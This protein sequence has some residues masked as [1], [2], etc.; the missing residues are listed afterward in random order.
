MDANVDLK[1]S[2]DCEIDERLF[3]GVVALVGNRFGERISCTRGMARYEP[4]AMVMRQDSLFDMASVTKVLAVGTAS[5]LLLD[6]NLLDL[7]SPIGNY[8]PELSSEA[9]RSIP[10]LFLFTHTS[11]LN[12]R[13]IERSGKAFFEELM[14]IVPDEAPGKEFCYSCLNFILLGLV[15]EKVS[16]ESLDVFCEKRIFA[17]FG[18]QNTGFA[19]VPESDHL[20]DVSTSKLGMINDMQARI[21]GR[22]V[23]NA[24]V[25]STA[26]DLAIWAERWLDALAADRRAKWLSRKTALWVTTNVSPL[27]EYASGIAFRIFDLCGDRPTTM[28]QSAFGHSGHTGQ[29]IWIDPVSECYS[30]VL[31][32]RLLP[33]RRIQEAG[34]DTPL[35]TKRDQCEARAR[36]ADAFLCALA[37]KTHA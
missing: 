31:T 1:N 9:T 12:N 21:A 16:S 34:D 26:D 29:S 4:T 28:S 35:A 37:N 18:M 32:N 6:K 19:P 10:L 30:I 13:K 22:P 5:S 7:N 20:V 36:I 33:V 23:G 27:E 25:F 15:I 24:G 2:I 17:P 14:K 11:G 8:V 3:P